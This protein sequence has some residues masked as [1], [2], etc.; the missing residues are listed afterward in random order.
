MTDEQNALKDTIREHRYEIDTLKNTFNKMLSSMDSLTE[1]INSQTTQFAVFAEKHDTV[2]EE[3][4]ELKRD[5]KLHSQDIA[6]MK[7][8]VEGVRGLVW[9]V[10]TASVMGG[11]GVAGLATAVLSMVNK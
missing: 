2:I 1:S 5:V 6:A 10:V 9:K 8:I 4:K 3:Q 7:P 11:V